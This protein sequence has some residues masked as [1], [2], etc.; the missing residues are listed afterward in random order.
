MPTVSGKL[1]ILYQEISSL[2]SAFSIK[3]TKIS[4]N[5]TSLFLLLVVE[6][7]A[8]YNSCRSKDLLERLRGL[9]A[10]FL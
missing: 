9:Q 3:L 4:R 10:S 1:D 2:S 5:Q 7:D 6:V 8:G